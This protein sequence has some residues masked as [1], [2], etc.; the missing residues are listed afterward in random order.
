AGVPERRRVGGSGR[1]GPATADNEPRM[2]PTEPALGPGGRGRGGT[3]RGRP[4]SEERFAARSPS[5]G[6]AAAAPAAPGLWL[7]DGT[8]PHRRGERNWPHGRATPPAGPLCA[9]HGPPAP[10]AAHVRPL[11]FL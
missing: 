7:C 2:G 1:P 5:A 9:G 4:A 8:R 10:S 3:S 11:L 6:R